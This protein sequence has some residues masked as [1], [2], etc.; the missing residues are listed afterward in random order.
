MNERKERRVQGW[1]DSRGKAGSKGAHGDPA[2]QGFLRILIGGGQRK[3]IKIR[4]GKGNV[5]PWKRLKGV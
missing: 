2:Q 5:L 4:L 1:T 3:R